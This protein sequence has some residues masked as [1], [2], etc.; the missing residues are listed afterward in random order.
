[1][2]RVTIERIATGGDGVGYLENG[3][4]VFVPRSAPGDTVDIELTER[5]KRYARG[6]IQSIVERS[7]T[8]TQPECRHFTADE[9]GGCQLQHLERSVQLDVKRRIVG[10]TL[11]RIGEIDIADPQI[12]AS[13]EQW[14]YRTRVTLGTS[15]GR[16]GFRRYGRHQAVFELEDC[17][18]ADEGVMELWHGVRASRSCLPPRFTRLVLRRDADGALHVV[19]ESPASEPWDALAMARAVDRDDVSYWWWP[20]KGAPRVVWGAETGYPAVAFEQV[21]PVGARVLQAEAVAS[22][23]VVDGETVWDLYAGYGPTARMIARAGGMVWAVE[24]DR[25]AVAWA[26]KHGERVETVHWVQ[27][28]VEESLHRLPVPRA[29]LANPPRAGLH[30]RVTKHLQRWAAAQPG[31]RLVYVSCDPA[32]LAR[33]LKRMP[34]LRVVGLKAFDLFPQTSHVEALAVVESE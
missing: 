15:G 8:R 1:M 19:V 7:S 26:R 27:G 11:R 18:I 25:S 24:L 13:P 10:D 30:Q 3:K 5:H 22:L 12:E 4:T 2:T 32:T 17:L 14:R 6:T 33:D 29:V 23:G 21:N 20:E 9:C 31:R 16:I 34:A 28:L